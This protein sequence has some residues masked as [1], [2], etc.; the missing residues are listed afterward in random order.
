M[1]KEVHVGKCREHQGKK[2]L[3]WCMLQMGYYWPTTKKDT[4]EFVKK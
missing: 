3:Y 4:T 2:K 1:I